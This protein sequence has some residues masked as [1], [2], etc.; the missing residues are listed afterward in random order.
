MIM[1]E[2]QDVVCDES[3]LTG[4][5]DG[6]EKVPLNLDNY[7]HG[8]QC[9]MIAKSLITTGVGKAIVLAVGPQTVAGVITLKTQTAAE[10]TQLQKKLD[11][12]AGQIGNLGLAVAILTFF[13]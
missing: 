13:A 2:G 4:E 11:V 12:I 1:V 10:Q 8:Y 6:L 7:K 9:T 3:E 5:P